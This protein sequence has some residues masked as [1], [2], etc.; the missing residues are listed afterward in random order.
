MLKA[1]I[2][3][4]IMITNEKIAQFLWEDGSFIEKIDEILEDMLY[5]RYEM[6]CDSSHDAIGQLTSADYAQI[7]GALINKLAELE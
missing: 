7:L 4:E 5:D 1:V 3:K 2:K 6:D